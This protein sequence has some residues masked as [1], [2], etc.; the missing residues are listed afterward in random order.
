MAESGAPDGWTYEPE[1]ITPAEES[2]IVERVAA[3]PF[4]EVVFRGFTAKRRVVQLGWVYDFESRGLTPASPPEPWLEPLREQAGRMA[5][6]DPAA[7]EEILVTEYQPG[8]QIGW[9]RDAP[10]F[11]DRVVGVSLLGTCRMRFRRRAGD[12]WETWAQVL[13]PRSAYVIGGE[14]RTTWYHSIPAAT[15]LRYSITFRTLKRRP[16]P[17]A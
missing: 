4:K 15:E 16:P 1:I 12:K 8:A 14:A 17:T 13:E 7:F 3:L 10:P 6:T 5:E 9:H 11:G 2:D